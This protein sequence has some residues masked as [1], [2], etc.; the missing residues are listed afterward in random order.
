MA[1]AQTAAGR[2]RCEGET[3]LSLGCSG[4]ENRGGGVGARA[5]RALNG[6]RRR[7][8]TSHSC[9]D[10][11]RCR[12][13]YLFLFARRAITVSVT[14]MRESPRAWHRHT[15]DARSPPLLPEL[16]CISL[17]F[18]PAPRR[19]L[20]HPRARWLLALSSSAPSPPQ[21]RAV[22]ASSAFAPYPAHFHLRARLAATLAFASHAKLARAACV[23]GP[24]PRSRLPLAAASVV[25]PTVSHSMRE[26]PPPPGR[27]KFQFAAALRGK[28]FHTTQATG[29]RR[30]PWRTNGQSPVA[31]TTDVASSS[32]PPTST[33]F[34]R[35]PA[36]TGTIRASQRVVLALEEPSRGSRGW[37]TAS[38][39]AP[40][41]MS[42]AC[43]DPGAHPTGS[44]YH[45]LAPS[46][47]G[48]PF[49]RSAPAAPVYPSTRLP[50]RPPSAPLPG[51]DVASSPSPPFP[52]IA[53]HG[54]RST[55]P[56]ARSAAQHAAPPH[57]MCL[58]ASGIW[59]HQH[60]GAALRRGRRA[61][62]RRGP[63]FRYPHTAERVPATGQRAA[64]LVR[65]AGAPIP[66][67]RD[68]PAV[69]AAAG[70]GGRPFP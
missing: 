23:G 51:P 12:G 3:H 9:G 69:S 66:G 25:V 53:I 4:A 2:M 6:A 59:Q 56:R 34:G 30:S 54:P 35:S 47:A 40:T 63:V 20:R 28:C 21:S 39:W 26:R 48:R 13:R 61:T 33:S 64:L 44:T 68:L 8:H 15:G 7:M 38:R 45:A 5:H 43:N 1:R 46:R 22:S 58:L 19:A 55:A 65:T 67:C 42:R 60:T 11:T 57:A 37:Q 49:L 27:D 16:T 31:P 24:P 70:S 17:P 14:I 32:P 41:A 62:A 10:V 18:L 29:V 50:V 36:S 52:P